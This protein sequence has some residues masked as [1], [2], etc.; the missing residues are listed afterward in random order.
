MVNSLSAITD[1]IPRL[2]SARSAARSKPDGDDEPVD[3]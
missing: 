3:E 2:R 1:R